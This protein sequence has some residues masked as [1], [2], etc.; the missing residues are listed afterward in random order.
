MKAASA[1]YAMLLENQRHLG[2]TCCQTQ[3]WMVMGCQTSKVTK[4]PTEHAVYDSTESL[5]LAAR[6]EVL[7]A[8]Y[9]QRDM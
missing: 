5:R 4:E 6:A 7:Q 1:R 3:T 2:L 8:S 9:A